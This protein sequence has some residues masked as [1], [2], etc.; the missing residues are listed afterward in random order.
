MLFSS[1]FYTTVVSDGLHEPYLL[2]TNSS[3]ILI[4]SDSHRGCLI[5]KIILHACHDS[6]NNNNSFFNRAPEIT[7]KKLNYNRPLT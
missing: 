1:S 7:D 4:L 5:S 3:F 6:K 2:L